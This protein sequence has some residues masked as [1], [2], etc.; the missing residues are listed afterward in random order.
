[1]SVSAGSKR[2]KGRPVEAGLLQPLVGTARHTYSSSSA[3]VRLR[4]NEKNRRWRDRVRHDPHRLHLYMERQRAAVRRYRDKKKR[5]QMFAA[6][7]WTPVTGDGKSKFTLSEQWRLNRPPSG[8]REYRRQYFQQLKKNPERYEEYKMRDAM[9]KRQRRR[10]KR[11]LS[12]AS[13]RGYRSGTQQAGYWRRYRQRMK[14]HEPEKYQ[15][16]LMKAAMRRKRGKERL[17]ALAQQTG[18]SEDAGQGSGAT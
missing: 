11:L 8:T 15:M 4:R 1:M 7:R 14:L 5:E 6:E 12:V 18:G 2:N 16:Y 10:Q 17:M 9:R 3:V 13:H